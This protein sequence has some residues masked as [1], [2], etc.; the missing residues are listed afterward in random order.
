MNQQVQGET[1][2]ALDSYWMSLGF[3]PGVR[4]ILNNIA[5]IYATHPD[6]HFRN[7]AK[8][9][10]LLRPLAAKADSDSFL[11]DTLAAAYAETGRFDDALQTA[12]TAIEKARGEKQSPESIADMQ[13]RAALY[14]KH[15]P[16]RE[17]QLLGPPTAA[18]SEKRK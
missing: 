3:R 11:L 1:Q 9:V 10:D 6:E 8:A 17:Q 16:F 18:G 7:G 13:Q 4:E 5:W 2:K 12:E 14:K 15:Q